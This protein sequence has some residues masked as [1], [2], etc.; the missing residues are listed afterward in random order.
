MTL[1]DAIKMRQR[2]AALV[3]WRLSKRRMIEI[4][5][6]GSA[7]LI[8]GWLDH[9]G[10]APADPHDPTIDQ[11]DLPPSISVSEWTALPDTVDAIIRPSEADI[12][13]AATALGCRHVDRG[14][15]NDGTIVYWMIA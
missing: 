2:Q 14:Y 3:G 10:M 9:R 1:S 7:K 8:L 11:R 12:I 13:D 6:N 4:D 5:A 15:R